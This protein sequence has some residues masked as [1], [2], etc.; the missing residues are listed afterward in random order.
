M[1]KT[2]LMIL[3]LVKVGPVGASM[4]IR[5]RVQLTVEQGGLRC[6]VGLGLGALEP[7]VSE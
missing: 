2:V 1:G 7:E 3:M 4:G 5:D 6:Y